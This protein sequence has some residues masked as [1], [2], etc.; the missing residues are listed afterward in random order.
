MEKIKVTAPHC[1]H[2]ARCPV[3]I[4]ALNKAQKD[5]LRQVIEIVDSMLDGMGYDG[6]NFKASDWLPYYELKKLAEE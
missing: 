2:Q 3:V 5:T 4:E 1:F 6:T